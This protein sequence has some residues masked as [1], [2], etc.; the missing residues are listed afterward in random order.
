MKIYSKNNFSIIEIIKGEYGKKP[1]KVND[2]FNTEDKDFNSGG[3]FF[4]CKKMETQ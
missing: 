1:E 2:K 4:N 3:Y